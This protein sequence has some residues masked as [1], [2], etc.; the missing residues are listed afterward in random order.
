[1]SEERELEELEEEYEDLDDLETVSLDLEEYSDL[2]GLEEIP[3]EQVVESSDKDIII[4]YGDRV[5]DE[6]AKLEG[7]FEG[8]KK[9]LKDAEPEI[10]IRQIA[11]ILDASRILEAR[12]LTAKIAYYIASLFS[13]QAEYKEATEYFLMAVSEARKSGNK[14]LHLDYLTPFGINL[15]NFDFKDASV[16]FG[17]AVSLAEELG[18]QE[19]YAKNTVYFADCLSVG[20][21]KQAIGLY[22][23]SKDYFKSINDWHWV[24]NIDFRIGNLY[25]KSRN[26]VQ[27]HEFLENAR[28]VLS[29]FS[30][31]LEDLQ[32][33]KYLNIARQL[34]YSGHSLKSRLNLP[35]PEPVLDSDNV[36]KVYQLLSERSSFDIIKGLKNTKFI[37]EPIEGEYYDTIKGLF[38]DSNIPKLSDDEIKKEIEMYEDIGD[39]FLKDNS[40]ANSFYN[41]LA[42]QILAIQTK[43]GKR[44]EKINKKISKTI[45][46]IVGEGTNQISDY[47]LY[48]NYQIALGISTKN[49]KQTKQYANETIDLAKKKDNPLYEA[50][51]KEILAVVESEKNT[52]KAMVHYESAIS[53][54]ESLEDSVDL[55]RVLEN[56]GNFILPLLNDR[57]RE[58]LNKALEIATLLEKNDII[59]RIKEKL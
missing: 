41:F 1:M 50:L 2:E 58:V 52:E 27:A 37:Q 23:E 48:I 47:I 15:M 6:I 14:E 46:Q 26:Y 19:A 4:T 35:P 13:S 22:A 44:V 55:L 49:L 54:Y 39:L 59:D 53:I 51:S 32:L 28:V 30:E 36:R 45:E 33:T 34:L 29:E 7:R 3:E 12:G 11:E 17:Q 10:A 18:I 16:V 8:K 42:A 57:G 24:G 9:E 31:I 21:I 43:D 56:F 5:E 25:L 20:D 40:L 38:T